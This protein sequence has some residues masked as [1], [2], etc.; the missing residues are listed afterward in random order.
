MKQLPKTILG[1]IT[2]D[3]QLADK[4]IAQFRE[5]GYK[6]FITQEE[7]V[8][9]CEYM[10]E[11]GYGEQWSPVLKMFLSYPADQMFWTH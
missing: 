8:I 7:A 1:A 6:R 2:N 9:E 10:I 5:F 3:Y 4:V 11:H